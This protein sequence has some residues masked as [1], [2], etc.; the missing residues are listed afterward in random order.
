MPRRSPG[1]GFA[2]ANRIV[3]SHVSSDLFRDSKALRLAPYFN[4]LQ[5]ELLARAGRD[6][7]SIALMTP[8]AHH[9]DYFGHAYLARYLS[10][11]LV[12]GGDLRIVG[13]RAYMKTLEGLRP[14]DLLMRCVD[15]AQSD[16]LELDPGGYL[17]PV[18]F[19][20]AIRHHPDLVTNAPGH[21]DRRKS[22]ARALSARTLPGR[23][24][25]GSGDAGLSALVA[26][27]S[28]RPPACL[29]QSR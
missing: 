6:D 5:G 7:A 19:V 27:R 13:N 11:L 14:I 8:G 16:P 29:R 25:R 20:Q 1:A 12:E 2:L 4:A 21:G 18:G 9:E 17:G 26:G 24:V 15:G 10:F 22:R 23:A 28:G 3:H